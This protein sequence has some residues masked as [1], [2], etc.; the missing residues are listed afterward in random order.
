MQIKLDC[1]IGDGA[2]GEVWKARDEIGRDVAVKIV[3]PADT[4]SGGA[5]AHAKALA[6]VNHDNVVRVYSFEELDD[7]D[8]PGSRVPCVVMELV[9]G[10][11]L[12]ERLR[13][14]RFSVDE[15][16]DIGLGVVEGVAEIH[17][18]GIAHGDLH[19]DNIMIVGSTAKIIDILYLSQTGR[20]STTSLQTRLQ[21]D[22]LNVRLILQHII[23]YSPLDP[24]LATEFNNLL[25]SNPTIDQVA[26][27]FRRLTEPGRPPDLATQV[28]AALRRVQDPGFV[29]SSDY[30]HALLDETPRA[31]FRPLLLR[32][33]ADRVCTDRHMKYA[34]SLWRALDEDDRAEVAAALSDA[35]DSDVPVGNWAPL[36]ML[37]RAFG[38]EGWDALKPLGQMRLENLIVNDILTGYVD[39]YRQSIS[40]SGALGT[41]ANMF[42]SFFRDRDALVTKIAIMLRQSWYTQN[43]VGTYMMRLIPLIADTSERREALV[44]ALVRAIDNDAKVVKNNLGQLPID[45]QQELAYRAD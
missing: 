6:L 11:T 17:A 19:S 9:A 25:G 34:G 3:R 8:D 40:L 22:L 42:W 1:K 16:R 2:Y 21:S 44:T 37:L 27:A 41:Y 10:P 5:L 15:V 32:M 14:A 13:G 36:L 24:A 29:D 28:A 38:P 31:V 23:L 35:L 33:I 30:A 39:A 20:L 12:S 18:R 7:P 4:L 26:D 43:Y 45:W